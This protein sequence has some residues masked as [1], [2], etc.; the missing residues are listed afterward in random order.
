MKGTI[1]TI[2][3]HRQNS[4]REVTF[5]LLALAHELGKAQGLET[6]C[7][8][9]E[10]EEQSLEGELKGWCERVLVLKA[11]GL[12]VF[13]QEIWQAVIL[14][15]MED[16]R[17]FMVLF[18]HT[19][20][21]MDLAP[22]LSVSSGYP[23]ATDCVSVVIRDGTPLATRQIYGGKLFAEVSLRPSGTYLISLRPGSMKVESPFG[24]VTQVESLIGIEIP[25]KTKKVFKEFIDT[26]AGEIDISQ[27]PFLISIGRG[28]GE[29]EAI[30][31]IRELAERMG[32]LISCSRPIVDKN[33]LPKYHQVGTSGKTVKPKVYMALGISGAFQHVAGLKGSPT[34]IAVNK[35]KRAPIFRVAQY[36]VVEDLFK[37]VGAL[38]EKLG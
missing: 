34:V 2:A 30:E 7:L 21:G 25:Q 38:K 12:E 5:E 31:E 14:K 19:P 27:A 4:L 36:G 16:R 6:I 29:K 8:L 33:W 18:C 28:I 15:V 10:G 37:I 23:L 17:P 22:S 1:L 11:K 24:L 9:L 13:N 20:W 26:G 3:E 35:D 32:A